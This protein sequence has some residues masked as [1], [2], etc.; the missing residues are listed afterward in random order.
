MFIFYI[1]TYSGSLDHEVIFQSL[2]SVQGTLEAKKLFVKDIIKEAQRF[3]KKQLMQS[4]EDWLTKLST[5]GSKGMDVSRTA[6]NSSRV[7][8]GQR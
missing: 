7:N 1:C 6:K 4:L 5:S 2:E 8:A 3:R